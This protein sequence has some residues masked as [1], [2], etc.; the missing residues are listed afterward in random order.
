MHLVNF[1]LWKATSGHIL[2]LLLIAIKKVSG[3]SANTDGPL[4][5]GALLQPP[6][7]AVLSRVIETVEL[8]LPDLS[9]Q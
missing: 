2:V 6:V 1:N 7:G 3:V 4:G 5:V 9:V 8:V